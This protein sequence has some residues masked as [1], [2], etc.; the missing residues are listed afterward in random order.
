M[1]YAVRQ[2]APVLLVHAHSNGCD[3]GDMRQT[4]Q[5]ISESLKVHVMSFEFPGYGLHLGHA[6]MRSID[7]AAAAVLNY[8]VNDLKI[9]LTQVVWYGRSIGSGPAMRAVH[10]ISQELKQQPG[11]VVLQCG[12]ANFPEVAGHLFGRV[13]KRLVSRLWPNEADSWREPMDQ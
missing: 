3:I 2:G 5:S 9:N 11:G 1:L 8:I 7:E 6:S 12:F 13:A 10:R 4:L